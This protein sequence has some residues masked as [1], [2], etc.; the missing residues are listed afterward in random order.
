MKYLLDS[1]QHIE[2]SYSDALNPD[3]LQMDESFLAERDLM[4][5]PTIADFRALSHNFHEK[6]EAVATS[7]STLHLQAPA[8]VNY[9]FPWPHPLPFASWKT[10][11][12]TLRA[13]PLSRR[14]LHSFPRSSIPYLEYECVQHSQEAVDVRQPGSTE[15]WASSSKREA[16]GVER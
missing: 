1:L 13:L 16:N 2:S 11:R 4:K 12:N 7:I 6:L 9:N 14:P 5:L 3:K 15:H 8:V 10:I